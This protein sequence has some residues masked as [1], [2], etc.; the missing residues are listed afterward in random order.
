MDEQFR[1][2]VSENWVGERIVVYPSNERGETVG[3]FFGC[4]ESKTDE[5]IA[6]RQQYYSDSL[7]KLM[8]GTLVILPWERVGYVDLMRDWDA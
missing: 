4:L 7:R 2:Q 5:G 1:K 3:E 8:P 6:Y